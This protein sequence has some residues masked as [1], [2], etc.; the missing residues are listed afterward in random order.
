MPIKLV[1]CGKQS[2]YF[3]LSTI[4]CGTHYI[5]RKRKHCQQLMTNYLEPTQE[6]GKQLFLRQIEREVVMLN[7]LRCP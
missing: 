7:L 5:T 2:F 1:L 4:F 6:S 3:L